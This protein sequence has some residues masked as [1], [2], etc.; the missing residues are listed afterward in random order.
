MNW[1]DI[2]TVATFFVG[3]AIIGAFY[4]YK[5]VMHNVS[6]NPR[7]MIEILEKIDRLNA[8]EQQTN[9][10]DSDSLNDIKTE[11]HHGITYLFDKDTDEFLAQGTSYDDALQIASKRFPNRFSVKAIASDSQSS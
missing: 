11:V 10:Q 3:G 1:V 9:Q 8:K 4:V 5:V 2:L 6:E 7:K